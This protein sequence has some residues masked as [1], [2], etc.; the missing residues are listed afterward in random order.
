[1]SDITWRR[2]FRVLLV[3]LAMAA[4]GWAVFLLWDAWPQ[5]RL[6]LPR[7]QVRWLLLPLVGTMVAGYLGFEAFRT[8]FNQMRPGLFQRLELAH[9]YFTGQLMKHLPGRIWSVAYQSSV[10]DRASLPEWISVTVAHMLLSIWFALWT[11]T[12]VFGFMLEWQL[13]VLAFVAGAG[14]Y[15]LGWHPR[16]LGWMPRLLGRAKAG[17]L[18]SL[19]VAVQSLLRVD[20]RFK[21]IVGFWLLGSWFLYLIAWGGYGMA[22]PNLSAA[23]GIWLCAM[24]TLAWFVGYISLITPSGI[25][26]RELVFVLLARDFPPDAVAGMALLGRF[27]LLLVDVILGGL[28]APFRAHARDS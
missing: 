2:R 24:Y 12:S 14:I 20:A 4:L 16:L 27:T 21:L 23:D 15:V 13:G 1:M 18:T 3:P 8:L 19:A 25:G 11:S 28:F 22:W 9:L 7:L 26:I 5:L 10:G 6:N 17:G